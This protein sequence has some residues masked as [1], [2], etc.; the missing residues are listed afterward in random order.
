MSKDLNAKNNLPDMSRGFETD[1][2]LSKNDAKLT[3]KQQDHQEALNNFFAKMDK[4]VAEWNKF[5]NRVWSNKAN[6]PSL[7][8]EKSLTWEA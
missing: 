5:L 4:D 8:P 2:P 6:M 1:C 7:Y 3:K